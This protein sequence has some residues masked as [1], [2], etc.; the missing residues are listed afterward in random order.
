MTVDVKQFVDKFS[1]QDRF[2]IGL[3]LTPQV[4]LVGDKIRGV[5]ISGNRTLTQALNLEDGSFFCDCEDQQYRK[6]ACKHILAVLIMAVSKF[7]DKVQIFLEKALGRSPPSQIEPLDYISTGCSSIDELLGG[8]IPKNVVFAIEG[9]PKVG[10]TWFCQQMAHRV[11]SVYMDTEGFL[12]KEETRKLYDKYFERWGRPKIKYEFPRSLES[13][14]MKLGLK[15]EI[16]TS[17]GGKIDVRIWDIPDELQRFAN[18]LKEY[19]LLIIDSMTAILQRTIPVPPNQ[20]MPARSALLNKVWGNLERLLEW[21]KDLT[22]LM[23][24]HTSVAPDSHAS[25]GLPWGGH[26]LLYNTK[27]LLVIAPPTSDLAKRFGDTCRRVIRKIFPGKLE[28]AVVV[29]LAKDMGY[30]EVAL[31]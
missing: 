11:P 29:A 14:C 20:N 7:P 1:T 10:K 21:R 12:L 18:E 27:Y 28:E 13:F 15:I 16:E 5:L 31:R 6:V 3:E 25:Y 26:S 2:N 30:T 8:G 23:T 4:E 17:A 24:H 9:P 19:E 22:V